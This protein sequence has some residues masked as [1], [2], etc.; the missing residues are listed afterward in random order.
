[1]YK[2]LFHYFVLLLLLLTVYHRCGALPLQV[3]EKGCKDWTFPSVSNNEILTNH[4]NFFPEPKIYNLQTELPFSEHLPQHLSYSIYS[5]VGY[6]LGN[7]IW[8]I[9]PDGIVVVDVLAGEES[10]V[11]VI[12]DMR[13]LLGLEL[14]DPIPLKAIIYTHNHIDHT[15]GVEGYLRAAALPACPAE[16]PVASGSDGNY[17]GRQHC[18]E[19][20]CQKGVINAVI[21]TGTVVGTMINP[22]SAYM[23]GNFLPGGPVNSGIYI[24]SP[25]F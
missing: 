13:G 12:K 17:T 20:I 25:L 16:S 10:V 1:M 15:G 14:T 4:T 23:Y 22:R 18:V 24:Y 8:L 11:Q 19:I 2:I 6:D 21:N 7:S 9:G 3:G 5:A